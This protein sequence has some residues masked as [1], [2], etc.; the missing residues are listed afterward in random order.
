MFARVAVTALIAILTT[1]IGF[2]I[3]VMTGV[4]PSELQTVEAINEVDT[5]DP[6]IIEYNS[7]QSVIINDDTFYFNTLVVYQD[8]TEYL[9]SDNVIYNTDS[10]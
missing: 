2:S 1:I 7:V 3:L 10:L 5:K 4:I 8:S 6:I 9:Y